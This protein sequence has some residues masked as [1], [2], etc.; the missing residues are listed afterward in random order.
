MAR[1]DDFLPPQEGSP[2]DR[3]LDALAL[4]LA[5]ER[6]EAINWR[7]QSGIEQQWQEDEEFYQGIDD[8]NRSTDASTWKTKPATQQ[9]TRSTVFPNIT[10][11]YVD[12]AAARIADM[13]LPNDDRS[14]SIK[15]TPIPDLVDVA[16]GNMPEGLQQQAAA[17]GA[18]PAQLQQQAQAMLAEA[19][20][21]AEAAGDQI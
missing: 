19:K 12:A 15:P 3:N 2:S 13:L 9:T 16:E 18:D 8:A 7:A 4:A 10:R 17:I 6:S 5:G 21:K 1:S 20:Q 11:P 14:W